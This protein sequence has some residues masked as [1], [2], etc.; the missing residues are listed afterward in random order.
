MTT[1]ANRRIPTAHHP[2]W[3]VNINYVY[4][5]DDKHPQTFMAPSLWL[6]F[7]MAFNVLAL[8]VPTHLVLRRVFYDA[9]T[10]GLRGMERDP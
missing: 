7:M 6:L 5:L 3:A 1:V 8:Y 10:K 4:G 2:H 9:R